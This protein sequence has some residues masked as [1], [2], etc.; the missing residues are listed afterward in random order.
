MTDE[1]E[2]SRLAEL[3]VDPYLVECVETDPLNLEREFVRLP[4][5]YAYWSEL[6]SRALTAMLLAKLKTKRVGA[7][8]R[9]GMREILEARKGKA[10][11]SMVDAAVIESQEMQDTENEELAA[12]V[13][14]VRLAGVL[15]AVKTK[16]EC[17]VSIGATLRKEMERDPEIAAQHAIRRAAQE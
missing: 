5:D 12:E 8:L 6:Y 1:Q 15:E 16:R 9:I 4:S 2:A 11:E 13:E 3:N 7:R 10:T 14:K 17:L